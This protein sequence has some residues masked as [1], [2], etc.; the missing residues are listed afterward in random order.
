MGAG[1]ERDE[2]RGGVREVLRFLRRLDPGDDTEPLPPRLPDAR[3]VNVEGRGE[4]FVREVAATE[5]GAPTVV[6]L[7]G[8]TLSADLNWF[9]GGYEVAARHGRVIAPDIRGHGRGLRSDRPFTLEA[10]A[11]DVAALVRQL[12]GDPA[13]LVGYSMGGSIAL[14]C[15]QRHPDVVAGL[16]LASC[17]LQWRS[18]LYERVLWLGLGLAEYVLRFGAPSGIT[19]RYL[20]HAV[21]RSPELDGYEGWVKAEARRGDASDIG[22][23]AKALAEFDATGITAHVG[24]PAAVVVTAHDKLIR[25][26]R[27]RELAR[28]LG[29]H[30]VEVDGHHNA[31]LVRPEEWASALDEAIGAVTERS[32]PA[33]GDP[34][35]R[36]EGRPLAD[37]RAAR[38]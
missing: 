16:V 17:A 5:A 19:D 21:E 36:G 38:G 32:A 12:G 1:M 23:A 37:V 22:C 25:A 11:D 34:A 35:L 14:L 13:V 24:C 2:V 15:A 26:R 29:A 3:I 27:Q 33:Q 20:R 18:S 7:H 9:S 28:A 8:W 10:A 4:M 6:L 31:W 30:T